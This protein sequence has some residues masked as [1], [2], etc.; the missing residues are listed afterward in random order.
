MHTPLSSLKIHAKKELDEKRRS[1]SLPTAEPSAE[2]GGGHNN[3]H[4]LS[5]GE[6]YPG[7]FAIVVNSYPCS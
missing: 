2:R 5:S 4:S 1:S 6:V 7:T 3:E